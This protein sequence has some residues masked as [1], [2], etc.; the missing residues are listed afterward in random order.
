MYSLRELEDVYSKLKKGLDKFYDFKL[1]TLLIVAA[2]TVGTNHICKAIKNTECNNDSTI[3]YIDRLD[4]D[5]IM[6]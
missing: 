2:I 5:N 3:K 4:K 6:G 1:D